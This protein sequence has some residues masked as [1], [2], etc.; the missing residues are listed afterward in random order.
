M[1]QGR[2]EDYLAWRVVVVI[3]CGG[4][5]WRRR[6]R[7]WWFSPVLPLFS[8]SLFFPFVLFFL[9]FFL[10]RFF[11]LYPY[12]ASLFFLSIPLYFFPFLFLYFLLLSLSS[13]VFFFFCYSSLSL[14]RHRLPFKKAPT[15]PPLARSFPRVGEEGGDVFLSLSPL[16][17]L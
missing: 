6:C 11:P 5:R 17:F 8:L 14:K 3:V 10:S 13:S 4:W 7:R 1:E 2:R 9:F 16:F 15:P 12:S